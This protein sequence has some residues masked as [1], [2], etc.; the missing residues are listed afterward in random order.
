MP[1]SIITVRHSE[2]ADFRQCPLKHK[3]NWFELWAKP[4]ESVAST[5]GTAWHEVMAAHYLTIREHQLREGKFRLSSHYQQDVLDAVDALIESGIHDDL[6][7][8]ISWM[9][10][11]HIEKYGFNDGWEILSAEETH[12]IPFREKNG[13]AS[14]FHYRWTSDLVIRDHTSSAKSRYVVDHKSTANKLQQ[15]EIDL[16]DSLALYVWAWRQKKLDILAPVIMQAHTKKLKR[17]QTLGERFAWMP[18][19]RT[20]IELANVQAECL[21]IAKAIHSKLNKEQPYSSPDPRTCGWKCDFK[22]A[23]LLMRKS[24]DPVRTLPSLMHSRGYVQREEVPSGH[25][26]PLA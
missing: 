7:E 2:I 5:M 17:P 21:G 22:E 20:E 12:T 8:N 6:Q 19:Y 18:S 14:R 25:A 15:D 1:S 10:D 16:M 24:K 4:E 3:L 13:R 23:H 11:G 26:P 9:Y